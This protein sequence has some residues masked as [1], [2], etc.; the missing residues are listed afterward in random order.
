TLTLTLSTPSGLG[1]T[2]DWETA[3]GTAT[4]GSDYTASSGTVAIPPG[5]TAAAL[6]VPVADD[7]VDE[8]DETFFVRLTGAA[9][10]I[11]A[12]AEA[13]VTILDD[14][15]AR[16]SIDDAPVVEGDPGGAVPELLFRVRLATEADQE[17]TVRYATVAGTA[18]AGADFEPASGTLA[19]PPGE[20]LR[21]VAV[22]VIPDLLL[23]P[24]EET[25]TVELSEPTETTIERGSALGTILDDERCPGPNLLANPGAE[26]RPV[27]GKLPGW[28]EVEGDTWQ[29]RSADPEPAEGEA[30]FFAGAT[31]LGELAQD[32]DLA[33]YDVR[34]E[35]APGQRFA[36][37]ARLRTYDETP[38][39]T[40]R[41]VVEYR[42]RAN[43][44]VLDAFDSGEVVSPDEWR[45]VAD[46]RAA[47]AGTG[48]I[49]VRLVAARFT[50]EDADGYFDA[51]SLRSLRAPVLAIG[52]ATVY[53]GGPGNSTAAGDAVF[54]VTLSCPFHRE[55]SVDFA[56]A[57]GTAEAGEDYVRTSGTLSFPVGETA[58]YIR[59]PVVGD[60]EHERHE[61]FTVELTGAGPADEEVL[62]DPVGSGLIVNDD[63]CPRSPGFWMTHEELWPAESLVLGAA[64]Y[65]AT[66]LKAL[67][68]PRG[69]DASEHLARQL[70]ATRFN[71]L[72]GSDPFILPVVKDAD[73]FLALFP[74]GS[75]P[76]KGDKQLAN[77]IKD[78]L[79][80]YN[81]LRCQETPVV[82]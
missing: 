12:G 82:P 25:L 50:P 80:R 68:N 43:S 24:D 29:R 58:A 41:V 37:S 81:N 63:F 18:T 7:L 73:A 67:L 75:N 14:D 31:E 36:F 52:D 20:T 11:S 13:T 42:D 78:Q 39:D 3:D 5:L 16:I 59:V 21:T 47:P 28:T 55:V 10:A 4:A 45:E 1:I 76:Q 77:A 2:V 46:E 33:A 27:A 44:V 69:P 34:V 17:I 72:V 65:D 79:D 6:S 48:W 53:E 26:A 54:P 32:V 66:A 71:L 64:D 57:D 9:N 70:I 15:E 38:P 62:L 22:A 60:A 23:E 30:Y 8:R 19:F 74:F 40:A 51:L 56:T 61:T 35:A 49:R